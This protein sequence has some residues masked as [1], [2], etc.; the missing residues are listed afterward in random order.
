MYFMKISESLKQVAIGSPRFAWGIGTDDEIYRRT[1]GPDGYDWE[2]V[3]A[4][5]TGVIPLK[6]DCGPDGAT[7]ALGDDQNVYW[8]K[9]GD[10]SHGHRFDY[11]AVQDWPHQYI[12]LSVGAVNRVLLVTTD[13]AVYRNYGPQM[14]QLVLT[15]SFKIQRV[16]AAAD[17]TVITIS[18]FHVPGGLVQ[19]FDGVSGGQ[20]PL[21]DSQHTPVTHIS[22]GSSSNIMFVRDNKLN[23]YD[24]S[25]ESWVNLELRERVLIDGKWTTQPISGTITSV[26]STSDHQLAIV[27]EDNG[28]YQ[29]YL[30]VPYDPSDE[31]MEPSHFAAERVKLSAG[32]PPDQ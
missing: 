25:G 4:L 31:S 27:T 26:N 21:T 3:K 1:N 9:G 12:D 5:A 20:S 18:D 32:D 11:W 2:R 10:G 24:G 30:S 14:Q 16:A 6:I 15:E 8:W 17:A 23:E 13:N 29:A 22:A 19:V 7:Y 28:T